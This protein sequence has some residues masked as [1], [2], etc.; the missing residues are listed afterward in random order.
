MLQHITKICLW[1][2]PPTLARSSW[3]TRYR[4]RSQGIQHWCY[5]THTWPKEYAYEQKVQPGLK[6]MNWPGHLG[7]RIKVKVTGWWTIMLS[8]S[9]LPK[10]KHM[11]N[12]SCTVKKATSKV[13][14]CKIDI[15]TGS[16]GDR[17]TDPN[18]MPP[19]FQFGGTINIYSYTISLHANFDMTYITLTI[20]INIVA[21]LDKTHY[22]SYLS[23]NIQL[24]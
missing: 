16:Q 20:L 8:E 2:T 15:Q 1:N 9:V 6:F 10:D 17:M 14:V 4:S 19:V 21:I 3:V 22:I 7:Q 5:L 24:E 23:F 13:E 12:D 18:S 11:N